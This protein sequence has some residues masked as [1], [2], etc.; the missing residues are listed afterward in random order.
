MSDWQDISTAP[1]DGTRIL[2]WS[3]GTGR[4]PTI[5]VWVKDYWAFEGAPLN[6]G[7]IQKWHQ[8][9]EPPKERK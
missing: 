1:R 5:V 8:L 6:L 4:W 7:T 3:S 9:P 2:A